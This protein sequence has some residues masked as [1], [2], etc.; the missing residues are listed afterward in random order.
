MN[1]IVLEAVSARYGRTLALEGVSGGFA[2]GS[3]TAVV[4]A[5]GAGKSTLLKILAGMLAPSS[6]RVARAAARGGVAY[7]P[8]A[9]AVDREFPISAGAFVLSGAWNRVGAFGRI[10]AE[11][12]ADA[13]AALATVGIGA[14]ADRGLDELSGGQFQRLLFARL[15]LQDAPLILLD[16]PFAALD[17][18]TV[19]DLAALIRTWHAAGRTVVAALHELDLVREIFP[20]TLRLAVRPLGWGPT[21]EVLR[22]AA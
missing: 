6:G 8:Q 11:V 15:I 20:E 14:L 1:A 4:G 13:E 10:P 21:A 19:A 3:L 2:H 7:L 16:E 17:A 18:A 9:A 12:R 22:G 5:N